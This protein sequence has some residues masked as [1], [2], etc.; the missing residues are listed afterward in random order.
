[1]EPPRYVSISSCQIKTTAEHAYSTGLSESEESAIVENKIK[2]KVKKCADLEEKA[3]HNLQRAAALS[4]P[5]RKN[6]TSGEGEDEL[7]D[8]TR[9]LSRP[10][11]AF[12]PLRPGVH[13]STEKRENAS[14]ANQPRSAKL[15]AER[16]EW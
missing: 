3:G 6:M 1:V 14:S 4:F 7:G 2:E 10:A 15:D 9:R 8:G 16:A 13:S 5:P 12:P 11:R